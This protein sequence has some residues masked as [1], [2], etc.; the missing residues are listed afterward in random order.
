MLNVDA[1]ARL[2]EFTKKDSLM[3]EDCPV[4]KNHKEIQKG[5]KIVGVV[6]STTEYGHVVRTFGP[7]KGLL[8]FEDIKKRIEDKSEKKGKDGDE[9]AK[10]EYKV[11]SVV[12]AYCLFK[13]AGKGVA[14]TLSKKTAKAGA[15]EGLNTGSS[16]A[17]EAL[18]P[19]EQQI[20]SIIA[21]DTFTTMIKASVRKEHVG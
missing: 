17:M 4:Y 10:F 2:I 6:V 16:R 9:G 19:T 20:D 13:K 8:S 3:K 18:L 21:E 1:S 15:E 12:K 14:L 11:G 7:V 5:S